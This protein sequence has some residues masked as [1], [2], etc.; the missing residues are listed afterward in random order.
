MD[1]IVE[2]SGRSP[3]DYC[4]AKV[5]KGHEQIHLQYC[6]EVEV[7]FKWSLYGCMH[8]FKRKDEERHMTDYMKEHLEMVRDNLDYLNDSEG[9]QCQLQSK[10]MK[11]INE[12]KHRVNRLESRMEV[13]S[14]DDEKGEDEGGR[15]HGS[16]TELPENDNV[17]QQM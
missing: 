5:V 9:G 10:M 11:E 2:C 17:S 16:G 13:D 7:N 8:R 3:C 6:P 12:L 15:G 4:G 1:H 14:S